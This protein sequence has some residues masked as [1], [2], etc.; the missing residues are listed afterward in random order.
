MGFTATELALGVFRVLET[1]DAGLAADVIGDDFANREA[2]VAP[3]ACSIPG[4]AGVLASGAWMRAAF[5]DLR[6]VVLGAAEN[7]DQVWVRLRMRGRHTG[8]FV[9]YRDGDPD[10]VVPPTGREIDFEQIHVLDIRDGRV[11][12]HEAVRDDIAMLGQLGV[13]PPTPAAG[14]SMIGWKLTG[15]AARAA[16]TVAEQAAAAARL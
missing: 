6:F 5:A 16:A 12:R 4:P 13:F 7:D 11:V 14:L 2:A 3:P 15:R 1:G 10:Q 8:P 9:R